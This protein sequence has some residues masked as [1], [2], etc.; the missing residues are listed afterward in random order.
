MIIIYNVI[1][2]GIALAA[3]LI[4]GLFA[5]LLCKFDWFVS[6][7]KPACFVAAGV[8]ATVLDLWYRMT[9]GEGSLLQP[10]RGGHF[11]FIPVW[12]L[13]GA[14]II[15]GLCGMLEAKP[16]VSARESSPYAQAPVYQPSTHP[17]AALPSP[18]VLSSNDAPSQMPPP[19]SLKL[20]LLSGV[21]THRIA[22]INGEPFAQGESHTVT[23]GS[24]K[25][26]V[27]CTAIRE[28]SVVVAVSGESEPRELKIGEPLVLNPR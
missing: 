26:T 9:R 11:F 17:A 3:A 22:T 20:G 5:A 7:G 15:G 21:G 10:R 1:G 27:R 14:W 18:A 16:K 19:R 8:F 4:A 24:T 23:T 2:V 6:Y 28:R 13:G 25:V 12:I